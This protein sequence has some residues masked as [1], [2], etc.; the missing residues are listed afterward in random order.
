[1]SIE[2]IKIAVMATG[3]ALVFVWIVRKFILPYP[4]F[5]QW[6]DLFLSAN[7]Q[8]RDELLEYARMQARRRKEKKNP[9]A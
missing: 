3:V 8:Q 7:E 4:N 6:M 9:P 5:F 1:M 2:L